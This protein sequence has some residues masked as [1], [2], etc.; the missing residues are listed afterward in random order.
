MRDLIRFF[1]VEMMWSLPC[2]ICSLA[3]FLVL[4]HAQ[5][6]PN[7]HSFNARITTWAHLKNRDPTIQHM[8]L[9]LLYEL[10]LRDRLTP[11]NLSPL[12]VAIS[13]DA[14]ASCKL[15]KDWWY[16]A[17]EIWSKRG[18]VMHFVTDNLVSHP[19]YFV[20]NVMLVNFTF[21]QVNL[22]RALHTLFQG[23]IDASQ[24]AL[25]ERAHAELR[26]KFVPTK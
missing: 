22:D 18:R 4:Y 1:R 19:Q 23:R 3:V 24:C 8:L 6:S 7:V 12:D 10:Q 21:P 26:S 13:P 16:A 15:R 2:I 14:L 25:I 9:V 5:T 17:G 11:K 20:A